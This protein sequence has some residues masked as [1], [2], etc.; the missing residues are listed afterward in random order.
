M[1]LVSPDRLCHAQGFF[2][3]CYFSGINLD[4]GSRLSATSDLQ[5]LEPV[6]DIPPA[7]ALEGSDFWLKRHASQACPRK[8]FLFHALE[9]TACPSGLFPRGLYRSW[10]TLVYTTAHDPSWQAASFPTRMTMYPMSVIRMLRGPSLS[11]MLNLSSV[12]SE[13]SRAPSLRSW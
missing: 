2:E 6:G 9:P 4:V 10:R 7:W 3:H 11:R 8:G 1:Q 12:S 5:R 13:A